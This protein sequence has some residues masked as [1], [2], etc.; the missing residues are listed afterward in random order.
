MFAACEGP[1]P[2]EPPVK[3]PIGE[4]GTNP[5]PVDTSGNENPGSSDPD[6]III[7]TLKPRNSNQFLALSKGFGT[8]NIY[9]E[10]QLGIRTGTYKQAPDFKGLAVNLNYSF[11]A[12]QNDTLKYRPFVLMVHEGAF[13]YGDLGSEMGKAKWMARKG[14]A[15]AAINY[16][17]GFDGG[18]EFNTC[19]GN[20]T[21]VI[22]AIYRGVQDTYTAL[23]YF[24]DKS[25]EFGIDPGQMML[26]GSSAGSMIISALVYMDEADFEALQPG[27][28][29]TLGPL[30]PV[31][32]GTEFRVRAL[33]TY[34][35]YAVFRTAYVGKSNAKP[36]VFF[37]GTSDTVLPYIQG[38]LFSCGKYFWMQGAKPASERLH[39]LKMPY[40]L[41]YQPGKGHILTYTEEHI[42]NRFAQFM[43]RFW[44]GDLRQTTVENMNTIQDIKLP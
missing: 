35:G 2:F 9:S 29:K 42:A 40:D 43:K 44:S 6:P 21:E 17:L 30:D 34:L 15:T 33:L 36:T 14:Y 5:E 25:N 18:S 32:G 41:N 13:I 1:S 31:T 24:A 12:P 7:D 28:T 19:G 37:Q 39:S 3:E 26:A 38:N 11:L 4:P 27:I 20:N 16:R 8:T 23:H 10:S 22:Q